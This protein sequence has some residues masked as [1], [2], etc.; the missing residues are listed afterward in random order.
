MRGSE[1]VKTT[2]GVHYRGLCLLPM[3]YGD[4]PFPPVVNVPLPPKA[5]FH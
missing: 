1:K 4:V 5:V 3:Q 2:L